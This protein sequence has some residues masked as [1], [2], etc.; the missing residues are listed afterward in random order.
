MKPG[1]IVFTE[2][3]QHLSTAPTADQAVT[4]YAPAQRKNII[5]VIR[6]DCVPRGSFPVSVDVA[7]IAVRTKVERREP[8]QRRNKNG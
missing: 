6:E 7:F 1:W 3:G 4:D 2:E 8:F 5:A